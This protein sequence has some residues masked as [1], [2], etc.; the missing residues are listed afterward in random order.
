MQTIKMDFQSQSTPPVVPVMQSDAQSRFI[1]ITL[2]NGGVPYEAP[3][4]ASYTVQYRGPGANNMG[5]YDTITLSSGT[6]KAVIV[7]SASKNVV[8]LELIAHS[9]LGAQQSHTAT[10]HDTFF[11]GRDA[12]DDA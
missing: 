1:G 6:R 7:D 12:R 10:S 8:T 3:E 2:Y 11:H 5:W 4:G 9:L